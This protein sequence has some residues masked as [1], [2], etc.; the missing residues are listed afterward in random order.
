M[1]S[2]EQH[3]FNKTAVLFQN[4]VVKYNYVICYIE[5][6]SRGLLSTIVGLVM[7]VHVVDHSYHHDNDQC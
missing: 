1:N 6:V 3:I 2:N 5:S 4:S 7:K